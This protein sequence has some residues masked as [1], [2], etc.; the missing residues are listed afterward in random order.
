MRRR[1]STR[2][3]LQRSSTSLVTTAMSS[4]LQSSLDELVEAA[5]RAASSSA[6][7]SP[8]GA[9]SAAKVRSLTM[10]LAIPEEL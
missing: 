8:L 7:T 5:R 10:Y 9:A 6:S 2:V 4:P 1:T 3:A